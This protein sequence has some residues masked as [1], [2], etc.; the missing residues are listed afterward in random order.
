MGAGAMGGTGAGARGAGAGG[1]TV[2][3]GASVR[4]RVDGRGRAAG[5]SD[6]RHRLA[7]RAGRVQQGRQARGLGAWA[8]QNCAL[9]APDLIFKPVFDSVFFLSQ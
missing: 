1:P 5:P 6:G 3:G 7:G 8:G 4:G 2:A 9:G